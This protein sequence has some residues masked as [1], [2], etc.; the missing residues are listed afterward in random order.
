MNICLHC[1]TETLSTLLHLMVLQGRLEMVAFPDLSRQLT[2]PF[3]GFAGQWEM[4]AYIILFTFINIRF[5]FLPSR[6][7]H[8]TKL[9]P[10]FWRD[11]IY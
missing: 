3:K 9:Q 8:R 1:R 10:G 6:Y 4:L 7:D 11:P 2:L 5:Q